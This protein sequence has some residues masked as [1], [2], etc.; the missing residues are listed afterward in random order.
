MFSTHT[1]K[2]ILLPVKQWNFAIGFIKDR[3]GSGV[4]IAN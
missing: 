4:F 2:L 1:C 3:L